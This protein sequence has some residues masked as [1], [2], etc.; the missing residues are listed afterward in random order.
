MKICD[1]VQFYSPLSGGVKRYIRDK[2]QYLADADGVDH[3][4]IIPS[5]RN[6]VHTEYASRVYE[7]RSPSLI[8]SLSY[9][10]LMS[11]TRI[12]RILDDE[13]P[14]VL[15]VGDPYRSAWI[16]AAWG[17]TH[18][19]SVVSYYHSDYPRAL[20]RTLRRFGG[21]WAERVFERTIGLYLVKLY[22]QMDATAVAT[23]RLAGILAKMGIER[24]HHVPLGTNPDVFYPRPAREKVLR[25][26]G[27]SADT[28]LLLYVG[29]LAREK[30]VS[31]LLAMLANIGTSPKV[32]LLIVGDGEQAADVAAVAKRNAAVTWWPYCDTPARLAQAYSAADLFIHAGTC[33]TFGLVSLEAQACGA[34]VIAVRNGG[35]EDTLEG[36][37]PLIV[38]EDASPG[39]LARAVR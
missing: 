37:D 12:T 36:E 31:A 24:L 16:A 38:A 25:E 3:V 23:R 17:R 39:A 6:A 8:G 1:I 2:M 30:N 27:V 29:R 28:H 4:V 19:A 14:D 11:R 20:G 15:E 9:R 18:G 13:Q 34:R 35:V 22:N 26:L 21:A 32:H 5:D 33:E 7:L 10:V